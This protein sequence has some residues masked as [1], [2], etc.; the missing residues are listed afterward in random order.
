MNP[1]SREAKRKLINA[2]NE[3]SLDPNVGEYSTDYGAFCV[4]DDMSFLCDT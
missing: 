4:A 3:A 1:A 2:L